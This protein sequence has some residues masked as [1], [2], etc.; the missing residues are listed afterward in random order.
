M[1]HPLII[2]LTVIL[3]ALTGCE[4]DESRPPAIELRT[5]TAIERQATLSIL[6]RAWRERPTETSDAHAWYERRLLNRIGAFGKRVKGTETF[7]PAGQ[8]W[9][10][11]LHDH[12]L[13]YED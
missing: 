9:L 4:S 5:K 10:D 1:R 6:R 11:C 12:R 7:R 2:S 13:R 8:L 3:L